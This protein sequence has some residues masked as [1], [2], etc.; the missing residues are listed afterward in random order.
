LVTYPLENTQ[1]VLPNKSSGLTYIAK[2]INA[3]P[4]WIRISP[5]VD[6]KQCEVTDT[7]YGPEDC[8]LFE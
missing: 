6:G 8:A 7:V 4:E 3:H 5:R 1:I 2:G